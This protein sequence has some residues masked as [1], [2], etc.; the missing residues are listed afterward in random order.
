MFV[1]IGE[2][3]PTPSANPFLFFN[4]PSRGDMRS[5]GQHC[6]IAA[7]VAVALSEA[8]GAPP[9]AVGATRILIDTGSQ[10]TCMRKFASFGGTQI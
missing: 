10:A 9:L 8:S 6:D 3:E 1:T 5:V 4:D 7:T 2:T